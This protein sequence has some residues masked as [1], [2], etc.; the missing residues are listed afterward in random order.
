MAAPLHPMRLAALAALVALAAV[1]AACDFLEQNDTPNS[2]AGSAGECLKSNSEEDRLIF[3]PCGA[4]A[5]SFIGLPDTPV[6]YAGHAGNCPVVNPDEDAVIWDDACAVVPP[7]SQRWYTW[8]R[9]SVVDAGRFALLPRRLFY[10]VETGRY[11]PESSLS[12]VG[13]PNQWSLN[14]PDIDALNTSSPPPNLPDANPPVTNDKWAIACTDG[15]VQATAGQTNVQVEFSPSR[16]GPSG[17]PDVAGISESQVRTIALGTTEAWSHL[18]NRTTLPVWK[19]PAQDRIPT[20]GAAY[21]VLR[22]AAD[23]LAM[24]WGEVETGSIQDNAVTEDEISQTIRDRLNP[25]ATGWDANDDGVFPVYDDA[26][27]RWTRGYF[28]DANG[29]TWTFDATS[30]TWSINRPRQTLSL[31][32]QTLA[33]SDGNTITLPAAQAGSSTFV[34]LADTPAALGAA[35]QIPQMNAGATALEWATRIPFTQGDLNKLDDLEENLDVEWSA[36]VTPALIAGDVDYSRRPG[37]TAGG[38][39]T[40]E[41]NAS[42]ASRLMQAQVSDDGDLTIWLDAQNDAAEVKVGNRVVK[43]AHATISAGN[44]QDWEYDFTDKDYSGWMAAGTQVSVQVLTAAGL[45]ID[46]STLSYGGSSVTLPFVERGGYQRHVATWTGLPTAGGVRF[47]VFDRGS[48]NPCAH[49]HSPDN[50]TLTRRNGSNGSFKGY[51]VNSPNGWHAIFASVAYGTGTGDSDFTCPIFQSSRNATWSP[52][53]NSNAGGF[54]YTNATAPAVVDEAYAPEGLTIEPL[55]TSAPTAAVVSGVQHYAA[56]NHV[57]TVDLDN[58]GD[59][60]TGHA[61]LCVVNSNRAQP[62]Q[63]FEFDIELERGTPARVLIPVPCGN[64]SALYVQAEYDLSD[65]TLEYRTFTWSPTL[66]ANASIQIWELAS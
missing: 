26:A 14:A 34:G 23:G 64:G 36:D 38:S 22:R 47:Y 66:P 31:T 33:I 35:G 54:T 41:V 25:D 2:F 55:E 56:S 1:F 30:D 58:I 12:V 4:E 44:G 8:I 28:T 62:V 52:T 57:V 21:Q 42:S 65:N 19:L 6:T 45:E 37:S 27:D 29:F 46:G 32:G 13:N 49:S 53:L 10:N 3:A 17:C 43:L 51:N 15:R 16:N 18:G 7:F 11:T 20:G 5:G 59:Q 63:R 24:E 39:I 50:L 40:N 48:G 60:T 9:Q 61:F